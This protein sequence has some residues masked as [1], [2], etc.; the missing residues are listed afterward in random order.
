[1]SRDGFIFF[2][3]CY[4]CVIPC[5]EI[6]AQKTEPIFQVVHLPRKTE[7][8]KEKLNEEISKAKDKEA[9]RRILR[10]KNFPS[11]QIILQVT[12]KDNKLSWWTINT[13]TS[14]EREDQDV[15]LQSKTAHIV[16]AGGTVAD[17]TVVIP[18][19]QYPGDFNTI[20]KDTLLLVDTLLI[21]LQLQNDDYPRDGYQF[22][23]ACSNGK[24]GR[25]KIPVNDRKMMIAPGLFESCKENYQA[26]SLYNKK[27]P[28][29]RLA[30]C[31]TRFL[32]S[33][34]KETILSMVACYQKINPAADMKKTAA[35]AS[36]YMATQSASPFYPQL[37]Q[38]LKKNLPVH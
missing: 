10:L 14:Y 36:A 23:Y 17:S 7:Y 33:E 19:V 3:I 21:N 24:I 38:W 31:I 8:S 27:H 25:E 30:Y 22:N 15:I 18:K 35:F 16:L 5:A 32:T 20:F 2:I 1:M 12:N 13:T 4:L 28:S 26:F 11:A 29:E 9:V 6:Q 34:E 37:L